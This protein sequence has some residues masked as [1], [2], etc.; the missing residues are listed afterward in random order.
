MVIES[1]RFEGRQQL[2][3][4][5]AGRRSRTSGI[6]LGYGPGPA[7]QLKRAQAVIE[8]RGILV[9]RLGGPSEPAGSPGGI[10]PPGSHGS[11]R[12]SLPSPGSS[13][14]SVSQIARIHVHWANRAGCLAINPVH[15][16]LNRLRVRNFRYFFP[17]QRLR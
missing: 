1:Q 2:V 4:M 17:A 5:L 6:R 10:A 16:S 3:L 14:L 15:H 8:P 11:R 12:D 13:H 7:P 9:C